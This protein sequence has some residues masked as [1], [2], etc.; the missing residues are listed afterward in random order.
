MEKGDGR[1]GGASVPIT[2]RRV[3]RR[4]IEP[5]GSVSCTDRL[6]LAADRPF[7]MQSSGGDADGNAE[8][9]KI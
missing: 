6:R 1:A 9:E 4:T 3:S 5:E 8:A 2:Y 7:L